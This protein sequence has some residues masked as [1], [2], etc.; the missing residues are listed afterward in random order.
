MVQMAGYSN[1]LRLVVLSYIDLLRVFSNF[2]VVG[3]GISEAENSSVNFH[4]I[5]VSKVG[6]CQ[7]TSH[8]HGV[9]GF[10]PE[11]NGPKL[12]GFYLG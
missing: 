11:I 7:K 12:D 5:M 1:Q 6:P 4:K 9:S 2:Q 8:V 3:N 10:T